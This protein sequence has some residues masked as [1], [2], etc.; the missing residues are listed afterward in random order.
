MESE[1]ALRILEEEKIHQKMIRPKLED[2]GVKEE[3]NTMVMLR[4][5]VQNE[6]RKDFKM[7]Q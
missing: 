7:R 5:V 2:N 3:V 4:K 1:I 6:E